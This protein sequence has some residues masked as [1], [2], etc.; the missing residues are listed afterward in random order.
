MPLETPSDGLDLTAMREADEAVDAA[1][2]RI[3]SSAMRA[4]MES[5]LSQLPPPMRGAMERLIDEVGRIEARAEAAWQ[6]ATETRRSRGD[7]LQID[8]LRQMP[9]DRGAPPPLPAARHEVKAADPDFTGFGW[10]PAERHGDQSWRW[11]GLAPAASI[12]L[13]DLGLGAVALEL[14]LLFPFDEPFQLDTVSILADG[15]PLR[16]TPV[17]VDGSRA[18]LAA[19]WEGR[20]VAGVNLGLVVLGPSIGDPRGRDPRRLGVGVRRV[21]AE[22]IG[23]R[24]L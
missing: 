9:G 10:H 17:R 23:G 12:V 18:T 6:A 2:A 20:E 5:E 24:S 1:A 4:R 3:G 21:V 11:S 7:W 14:D 13:P 19:L 16:L 8:P 22:R 15:E